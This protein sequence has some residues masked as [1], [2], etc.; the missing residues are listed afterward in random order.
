MPAPR[1]AATITTVNHRAYLIG[2]MNYDANREIAQLRIK[3]LE[4]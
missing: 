3:G 4:S 2:G 1:E